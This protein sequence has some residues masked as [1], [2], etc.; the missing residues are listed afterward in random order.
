MPEL[1]NRLAA[2]DFM[3]SVSLHGEKNGQFVGLMEAC[4][5]SLSSPGSLQVNF[6][7]APDSKHRPLGSIWPQL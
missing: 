5:R 7:F 4:F 6:A 3:G 1:Q 2:L